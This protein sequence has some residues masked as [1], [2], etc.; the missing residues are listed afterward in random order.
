MTRADIVALLERHRDAFKRRDAE[1]LAADFAETGVWEGPAHGVVEGR[2]RILEIYNYWF[3]AFPDLQI[4]WDAPLVDGDRAATFWKFAGTSHGPF[5]GVVGVLDDRRTAPPRSR[6]ISD[7]FRMSGELKQFPN[8]DGIV[9][10]THKS[11]CAGGEETEG[12]YTLRRT[13]AGYAKHPN[14]AAVLIIGLGCEFEPAAPTGGGGGAADR[15]ADPDPDH[16]GDRLHAEHGRRLHRA[17]SRTAARSQCRNSQDPAGQAPDPWPAMRRLGWL[18]RHHG[19]S[20]AGRGGGP[21]GA[22]RRHRDPQRDAG[23]LWRRHM[24][25]G[26]AVSQEVG[27]KLLD[28]LRWWEAYAA[29]NSELLDNNPS[30]GN[31]A[32]GLTTIL[33]KSLAR[34]PRAAGA[35]WSTSTNTPSR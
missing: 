8:V 7:H 10:L 11:G 35:I 20:G 27:Q 19:E 3:N 4:T 24:P 30:P 32:G 5:F 33:E 13:V 31:K 29:R 15:C 12:N 1:A 26:R 9:A 14:F 17:H 6:M 28:L 23:D 18:L 22:Q 34:P 16:P 21:A 25:L 2:A